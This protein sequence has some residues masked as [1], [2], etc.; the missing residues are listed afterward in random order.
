MKRQWSGSGRCR[1]NWNIRENMEE[2]KSEYL[3]K[4][5][6]C[7]HTGNAPAKKNINAMYVGV[8]SYRIKITGMW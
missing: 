6:G 1:T 7:I 3:E 8:I 5:K 4:E 2:R